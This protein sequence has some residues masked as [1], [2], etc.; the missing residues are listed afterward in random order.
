MKNIYSLFKL[1]ILFFFLL[2]LNS[3]TYISN[4]IVIGLIFDR[5]EYSFE[6]YLRNNRKLYKFPITQQLGYN[7]NNRKQQK[8]CKFNK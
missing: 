7:N 4:L 1:T 5:I 3:D 8:Y 6:N 2:I